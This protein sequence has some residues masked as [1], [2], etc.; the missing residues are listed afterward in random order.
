MESSE[1]LR[2]LLQWLGGGDDVSGACSY[3]DVRQKLILLF[4]CR[5]CFQAEELADEAI[6]RTARAL[7]KPDFAFDGQPIAYIRGVARNIY[8]EWL[9]KR[10]YANPESISESGLELAAPS[11][12]TGDR[13]TL[14]AC[15]DRCL[16]TLPGDKK[17]LLIRYYR[18]EKREK[19]DD[20]Q[21]LAEE[22]GIALNALRIQVFRLRNSMRQCVEKCRCGTEMEAPKAS[23]YL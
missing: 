10:R 2:A 19:I 18:N 9:R 13:E 15:L 7:L 20:R 3:E 12:S 21:L 14:F 17:S 8:L 5:G 11:H 23:P 1:A 6:D 16:N 22:I 4:R